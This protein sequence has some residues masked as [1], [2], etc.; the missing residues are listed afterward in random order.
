MC[1]V[2]PVSAA[3]RSIDAKVAGTSPAVEPLVLD[4]PTVTADPSRA[5]V[6]YAVWQQY[7]VAPGK[8][9]LAGDAVLAVTRDGG[10]SWSAPHVIL[11]HGTHEASKANLIQLPLMLAGAVTGNNSILGAL[12]QLGAQGCD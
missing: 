4:K 5:G 3:S 12:T 1:G 7:P 2:K 8:P 10:R 11:R 6:A 9:P